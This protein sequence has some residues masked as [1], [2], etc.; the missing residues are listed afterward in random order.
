MENMLVGR[1]MEN[2]VKGE[3]LDGRSVEAGSWIY[4]IISFIDTWLDIFQ[5]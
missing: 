2:F 5:G 3:P 1:F 4:Y